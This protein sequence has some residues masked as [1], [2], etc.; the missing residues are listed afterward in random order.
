MQP[1]R[2]RGFTQVELIVTIVLIGIVSAVALPRFSG[3]SGV[4]GGAFTDEARA[5]LRYAQRTAVASRRLVCASLTTSTLQLRIASAS[6]ATTCNTPLL[7]PTGQAAYQLDASSPD[8]RNL[9]GFVSGQFP[10]TLNFDAL[11]RP[12]NAAGTALTAV[13][14]IAVTGGSVISVE[15]ETGHVH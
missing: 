8:Y 10:G 12:V 7:D 1:S 4:E 3:G 2:T 11:G 14:T 15:P 13:T 6:G 5:A 9:T